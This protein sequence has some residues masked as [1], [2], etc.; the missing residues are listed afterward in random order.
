MK[1]ENTQGTNRVK[2][3]ELRTFVERIERLIADKKLISDD[4]SVVKAEAKA[5]G[6]S[7]KYIAALI[8]LRKLSPSEREEHEAMLDLY[9]SAVGMAK[10][11]PLFRHIDTMGVDVAAQEKVIDALKL[12]APET[13]ELTI[14][15]GASPKMRIWRDKDGVHVEEVID[16]PPSAPAT[17]A[18]P[19]RSGK[20]VRRPGDD[21]PDCTEDEAFDLGREARRSDRPI[22]ANPFAHDD[23]RRRR[24]DEGWREEDGGDGM[25]PG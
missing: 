1:D 15:V 23:K 13:G 9:M 4:I 14:Q 21:A 6:Y 12:L 7:P 8:K 2:G 22:I 24:W 25:G 19:G 5:A 20:S 11:T 16:P 10:D 18:E 3:E 17:T